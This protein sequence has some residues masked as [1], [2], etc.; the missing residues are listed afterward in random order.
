MLLFQGK[1]KE[2]LDINIQIAQDAKRISYSK[3][4]AIANFR[5]GKALNMRGDFEQSIRHLIIAEHEGYTQNSEQLKADINRV[6]G[7]NENKLGLYNIAIERE[8]RIL[9][10]KIGSKDLI[11]SIACNKIGEDFLALNRFDSAYFYHK[12]AYVSLLNAD[13]T[14]QVIALSIVCGNLSSDWGRQNQP[15]SARFY[16]FKS[17]KLAE[18]TKY[19]Y[20][21]QV[22]T[23]KAGSFFFTQKKYDSALVYF[24]RSLQLVGR[25]NYMYE[26]K[27]LYKSLYE[28]YS[29]NH[30]DS[31]S[32]YYLKLYTAISDSI[33]TLEKKGMPVAISEIDSDHER[34]F[35]KNKNR[36]LQILVIITFSIVTIFVLA[37][38]HSFKMLKKEK[39]KR[40]TDKKEFLDSLAES[41]SQAEIDAF[42]MLV[43]LAKKRDPA[44][45]IKFNELIPNF[46]GRLL[47]RF[48]DLSASDFEFCVY[49][50]MNFDTKEIARYA[51]M[52][53]RSV[54][55]KKYRIRKK[56]GISSHEDINMWIATNI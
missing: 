39:D 56:F 55:A 33:T 53:V 43:E 17:L 5:I 12:K 40:V 30:N 46:S 14:T 16:L 34:F 3:G 18:Q 19:P 36:L 24:H 15:D 27:S 45:F 4:V 7:D 42:S 28:T 21:L 20:A 51:N 25:S 22:A 35:T 49:L 52:T 2:Y 44:F 38:Y 29:L 13:S 23:K 6:Y 10:G 32:M 47:A 26:F 11:Y 54:E 8:K 50:K 41:R 37:Y 1:S 48:P 31:K 9:N